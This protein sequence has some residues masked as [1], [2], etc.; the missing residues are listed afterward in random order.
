MKIG[1][2]DSGLGGVVMM[3]SIVRALP[4]YDYMLFADTAHVPYGGRSKEDIYRLTTRALDYMFSHGCALVILACNTASANALPEIQQHWLPK[5]HPDRKVLGVI[6][7]TIEAC[8]GFTNV[9]VL[10]TKA[11][12]RSR[13][14]AREFKKHGW[15]G[16]LV[17]K[18]T[19]HLVPHLEKNEH[20]DAV[21]EL[22]TYLAPFQGKKID[23]V[24]LGC[25]HYPLLKK[26]A[27]A[28]LGKTKV[29]SQDEII[30]QKFKTYLKRH[31]EITKKLTANKKK[32][33]IVTALTPALKERV[34]KSFGGRLTQIAQ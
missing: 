31:P 18:S 24:I 7:P 15:H 8:E 5:H 16:T 34:A 9:G 22:T 20:E 3:E 1:I 11:T 21:R 32:Q 27:R 28:L 33:Y 23:A 19:P 10:A 2:F 17:M 29:I 30:P 25:T 6:V 4:Q 13:S 26:E 14:F 12:V